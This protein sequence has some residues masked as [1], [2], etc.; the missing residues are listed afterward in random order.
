ML[1]YV[2]P[3]ATASVLLLQQQEN[4]PSSGGGGGMGG[5]VRGVGFWIDSV[6]SWSA[7]REEEGRLTGLGSHVAIRLAQ[8]ASHSAVPTTVNS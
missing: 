5:G 2:T 7:G 4:E 6:K 8:P 1:L 3:L